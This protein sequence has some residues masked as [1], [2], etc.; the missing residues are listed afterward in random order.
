[1][2]TTLETFSNIQN[3]YQKIQFYKSWRIKRNWESIE[4]YFWSIE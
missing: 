2:F 4:V 3:S 1:L